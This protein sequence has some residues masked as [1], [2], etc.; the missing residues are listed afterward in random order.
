MKWPTAYLPPEEC[1]RGEGLR[2][3]TDSR[4]YHPPLPN[5]QLL[6]DEQ[7]H[8]IKAELARAYE[9][10]RAQ[11]SR[12]NT[13]TQAAVTKTNST[14]M[15]RA[16]TLCT[17]PVIALVWLIL[18]VAGLPFNVAMTGWEVWIIILLIVL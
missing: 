13:W 10:M 18:W 7:V 14:E 9:R 11:Q 16:Y 1:A 2:C 15:A 12:R 17:W 8:E 4:F 6:T 5:Q 3:L